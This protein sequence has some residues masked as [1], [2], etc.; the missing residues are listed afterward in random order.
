MLAHGGR[1]TSGN[2]RGLE[3]QRA[4]GLVEEVMG[5]PQ[6]TTFVAIMTARDPGGALGDP[7]GPAFEA[8]VRAALAPVVADPRVLSVAAPY[9]APPLVADRMRSKSAHGA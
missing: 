7:A 5:H 9:D 4:Q 3:S 2:I 8:A 1:L 6:E